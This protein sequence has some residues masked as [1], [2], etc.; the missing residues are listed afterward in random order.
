[1]GLVCMD[2]QGNVLWSTK[3]D[4]SVNRGGFIIADGKIIAL[5]GE[6]GILYM[7]K[8]APDKVTVIDSA[9]MFEDLKRRDNNIW[10]PLALSNGKLIIRNQNV[11]KCVNL[12]P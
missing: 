2:L 9:P 5:G 6:N 7:L 12:L 1:M 3:D 11:M 4:P 10:A 8:A